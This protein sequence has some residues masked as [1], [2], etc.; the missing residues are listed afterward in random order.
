MHIILSIK[1]SRGLGVTTGR[2]IHIPCSQ[3]TSRKP[4]SLYIQKRSRFSI[5]SQS[6]Q[7][8]GLEK[9]TGWDTNA[10]TTSELKIRKIRK[11]SKA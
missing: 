6:Y 2:C 1:P 3:H 10:F 11:Q 9:P 4:L 8:G 7:P 5:P